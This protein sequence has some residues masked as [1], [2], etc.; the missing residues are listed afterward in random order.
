MMN[1]VTDKIL[2]FLCSAAAVFAIAHMIHIS[3]QCKQLKEFYAESAKQIEEI[4]AERTELVSKIE[5]KEKRILEN[6]EKDK[7]NTEK[8]TTIT[9][10]G[11]YK[12]TRKDAAKKYENRDDI[13][14]N[15]SETKSETLDVP[16]GNNSFYAYM[17][18][19]K[20]T[21]PTSA[22][23]KFKDICWIDDMGLYRQCNDYV[24]ALGSFYG[25]SIGERY[26]IT[27]QNGVSFTAVLGDL[28]NDADTDPT[29]RYRITN[30][31][32]KNV[33]EFIVDTDQLS[34]EVK[35]SGNIGS[36]S[37]FDSDIASISKI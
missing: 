33:I 26:M 29:N 18:Y 4:K 21:D 6:Y 20:V 35:Q 19:D 2:I 22:Q 15:T 36:Y 14:E 24:I 11:A 12:D 8:E 1:K 16:D 31:E 23:Y 27:L 30:D 34:K 17:D 25:Q 9:N 3:V 32:R 7:L 5:K 37:M 28:K 10:K 13:P